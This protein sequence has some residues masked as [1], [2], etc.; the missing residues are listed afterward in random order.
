MNLYETIKFISVQEE[1]TKNQYKNLSQVQVKQKIHLF[2]Q[3]LN[4]IPVSTPK[5]VAAD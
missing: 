3:S 4:T 2:F 5:V 1:S